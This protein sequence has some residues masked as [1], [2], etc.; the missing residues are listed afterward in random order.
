MG[1]R[2]GHEEV[3]CFFLLA[4]FLIRMKSLQS[5]LA[6]CQFYSHFLVEGKDLGATMGLADCD[7]HLF[8]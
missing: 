1:G 8:L 6:C 7:H 3:C 4:P 5:L 2:G